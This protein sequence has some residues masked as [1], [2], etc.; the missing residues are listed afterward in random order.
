MSS[1]DAPQKIQFLGS[2]KKLAS[3]FPRLQ[4]A[5]WRENPTDSTVIEQKY[6]RILLFLHISRALEQGQI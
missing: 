3:L 1:K 4:N 2:I 6:V 5:N